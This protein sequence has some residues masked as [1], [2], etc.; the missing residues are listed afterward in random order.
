MNKKEKTITVTIYPDDLESLAKSA[1]M[2]DESGIIDSML[3]ILR[4]TEEF[5]KEVETYYDNAML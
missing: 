1:I 3:N 2:C 5:G 4:D